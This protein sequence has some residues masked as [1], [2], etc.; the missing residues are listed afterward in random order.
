M[1]N[2]KDT[3]PKL[4]YKVLREYPFYST[5][6]FTTDNEINN[7]I[8]Y[9]M[10]TNGK[11]ILINTNLIK[12]LNLT[13]N[14]LVFCYLHEIKH[15]LFLHNTLQQKLNLNHFIYCLATDI[16]INELTLKEI[17]AI[18]LRDKIITKDKFEELEN[19]NVEE[20]TTLE[21]YDILYNKFKK[22][23]K[24]KNI[25]S[26]N[27]TIKEIL[28]NIDSKSESENNNKDNDKSNKGN[29]KDFSEKLKN[30]S[31][32]EKVKEK[33]NEISEKVNIDKDTIREIVK[34][35]IL[36]NEIEKLSNEEKQQ[37]ANEIKEKIL[38][39]YVLAKQRGFNTSLYEK[40]INHLFKKIRDWKKILK[41]E[42]LNEIKGD[43]TYS[44]ISDLLQSLHIAGF[45]EIGNLPSL[46]NTYS[47]NKLIIA[48]DS[49]GS[50]EDNDYKDFLNEVYSI[51]KSVNVSNCEVI[52]FDYEVVKTYKLN[53][54]YQKILNDLKKRKG[55]GG[56]RLK[57]VLE[58]L[59]NKQTY[60]TILVVLTDGYFEDNLTKKDFA[61]FKKVI[62]VLS[63]DST[64]EN[65]PKSF[66]IK[67]IKIR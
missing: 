54:N 40:L 1:D 30:V 34:D 25:E 11:K 66:N 22:E 57:S 43:W 13:N 51:F 39:S 6:A 21:I 5:I 52:L 44:K 65:I 28:K 10:A 36:Q 7:N 4:R 50:I 8:P 67:I 45:K 15:I 32:N 29:E 24:L 58:Y 47:I 41:E 35:M 19:I 9:P 33:I 46:D 2:E 14:D 31:E 59:K 38:Q 18:T 64:S 23:N 3:I 12:K 56:T 37:L 63:K 17:Q 16:L 20:K 26:L 48:I 60:N 55:Y 53:G 42:I 49:S 27:N 62:F 61:K